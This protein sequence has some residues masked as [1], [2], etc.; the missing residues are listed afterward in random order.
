MSED[1]LLTISHILNNT[2]VWD[3]ISKHTELWHDTNDDFFH[4]VEE[5]I[6]TNFE[7]MNSE[8]RKL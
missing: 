1:N 8:Q 3:K 7:R 4:D 5:F 6:L 2:K